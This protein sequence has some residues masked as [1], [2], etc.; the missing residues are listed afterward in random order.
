M[1]KLNDN[2]F[3]FGC[4]FFYFI[5]FSSML[6]Y[7]IYWD[8]YPYV[9]S[10]V[11]RTVICSLFGLLTMAFYIVTPKDFNHLIATKKESKTIDKVIEEDEEKGDDPE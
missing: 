4:F 5:G 8:A 6:G 10:L 3:F 7:T 2:D 1:S 11:T 9:L